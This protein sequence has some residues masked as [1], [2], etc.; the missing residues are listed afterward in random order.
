[1]TT[2]KLET[3]TGQLSRIGGVCVGSGAPTNRDGGVRD[4]A[5]R[6]CDDRIPTHSSRQPDSD[7]RGRRSLTG[8]NW[9]VSIAAQLSIERTLEA[10]SF[11]YPVGTQQQRLGNFQV[12]LSSGLQIDHKFEHG[13]LLNR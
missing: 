2:I 11:D 5:P 6:G 4:L 10:R 9:S 7:R 13:R 8:H 3:G 12:D 1:V